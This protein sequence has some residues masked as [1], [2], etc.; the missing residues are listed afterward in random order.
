MLSLEVHFDADFRF[1]K[2]ISK[3]SFFGLE[4]GLKVRG[5]TEGPEKKLFKYGHVIYRW[6]RILVQISDLFSNVSFFCVLI[7]N[8]P[9]FNGKYEKI[10]KI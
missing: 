7:A 4:E 6:K 9:K 3:F 2:I 1:K 5:G 8:H 10:Q